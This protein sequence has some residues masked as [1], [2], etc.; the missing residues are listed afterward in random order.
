MSE[1]T[2]AL[3]AIEA[4]T[5]GGTSDLL[6]TYAAIRPHL[7]KLINALEAQGGEHARVGAVVENLVAG[8]DS[9][10]SGA[11]VDTFAGSAATS[12]DTVSGGS[13]T[14]PAASI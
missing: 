9:V 1:L 2:Q 4:E 14:E 5:A 6:A 13:M 3:D 12:D 7:E 11:P 8:A 10:S